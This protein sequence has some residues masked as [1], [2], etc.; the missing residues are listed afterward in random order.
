M[1]QPNARNNGISVRRWHEMLVDELVDHVVQ[2][3]GSVGQ[4]SGVVCGELMD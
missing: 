2:R 1:P 3:L 4:F